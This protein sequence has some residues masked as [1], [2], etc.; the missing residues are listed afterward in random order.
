MARRLAA[1]VSLWHPETRQRVT[2]G[3][4]DDVPAWAAGKITNPA[5]WEGDEPADEQ[6]ARPKGNAS[7][8]AWAE[9]AKSKGVDVADADNRDDI[10][11]AVEAATS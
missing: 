5:A 1:Y 10:K 4:K 6:D 9:Y 3:P 2:F 7:R 11:A 8:E